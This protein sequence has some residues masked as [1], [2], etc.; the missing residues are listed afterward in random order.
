V[1]FEN[2]FARGF[3]MSSRWN[4]DPAVGGAGV[5]IDNGTHSLDLARH[6][7][8][9]LAKVLASRGAAARLRV[10]DT[11][12]CSCAASGGDRDDRPVVD[13]QQ[14]L[15]R[16]SACSA[17]RASWS[18]GSSRASAATTPRMDR[19]RQRLRQGRRV[20]AQL[21]NFAR[22]VQG[23]RSRLVGAKDILGSVRVVEAA[24]ESL[25]RNY[26]TSVDSSCPLALSG[27]GAPGHAQVRHPTALI[28]DNVSI[29]P[30]TSIWD[31]VHIRHGSTIGDDCIVG[32]RPTSPTT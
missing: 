20:R 16:T 19:D 25:R 15:D 18:A 24:Y 17:P 30:G 11:V 1:L 21:N 4:S 22:A 13:D 14:E 10:E 8:G 12:T 3:D 31:N 7:L 23:R 32:R 2:A 5:L 26:W 9:P 29:R 28:E 6:F 27:E